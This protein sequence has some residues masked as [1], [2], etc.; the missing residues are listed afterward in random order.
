MG[1]SAGSTRRGGAGR[2]WREAYGGWGLWI[3]GVW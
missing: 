1:V 3:G 2:V